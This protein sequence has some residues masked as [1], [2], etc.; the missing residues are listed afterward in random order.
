MEAEMRLSE[1]RIKMA[2]RRV[3]S[4]LSTTRKQ[5]GNMASQLEKCEAKEMTPLDTFIGIH[6]I[7][8]TIDIYIAHNTISSTGDLK[9][10]D[11]TTTRAYKR[12]ICE[13]GNQRL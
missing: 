8:A 11:V 2:H 6:N 12:Q 4:I 9:E 13:S 3:I 1:G 7:P 5:Q 10:D